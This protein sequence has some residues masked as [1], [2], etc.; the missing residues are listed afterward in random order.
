MAT[1]YTALKNLPEESSVYAKC[2]EEHKRIQAEKELEHKKK[3][4]DPFVNKYKEIHKMIEDTDKLK[5]LISP[6]V[7]KAM[8]NKY[9]EI[10]F[11]PNNNICNK[12][13]RIDR[14]DYYLDDTIARD[15]FT[16]T[17]YGELILVDV[18]KE[19]LGQEFQISASTWGSFDVKISWKSPDDK[20]IIL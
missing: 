9:N 7:G 4:I 15:I 2:L 1:S 16:T 12:I 19:K 11:Y 14:S 3:N 8:S 17:K 18:L 6:A 10:T 20:C 5:Q 13:F